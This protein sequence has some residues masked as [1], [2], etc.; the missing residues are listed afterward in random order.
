MIEEKNVTSIEK[1][2]THSYLEYAMSV[3]IGRAL[4][5]VR[6]GLKPVHRRVLFAMRQ[7]RNDWNKPYKKSA[8]VVGDVIGKY[9]PH[10]D[11]A[12]YDTIVRMAQNFSLRYTLIDGQGNFGS[13][14]GD[15]PAAMRYT[16]IR[17]RK[18]AHLMLSDIEK[19][20]VDWIPNYDET[21]EEP[22]VFPTKFPALLV[23]GSS[24]I[25]VGMTTNIPPHNLGE[26]CDG[27]IALL[28]NPAMDILDLM[29]YIPGPDFP[30]SG[31]IHGKKGIYDAYTTGR[32][33][34]TIRAKMEVELNN[35]T[36][37]ETIVVTELPYQ[38]NKARLVEKID[39][40]MREKV[41]EG[42]AYVRDESD[43]DGMRIAIGLKKDQ[44]AD[45]VINQLYKHTYMQSS[46]GIIFLAVINKRPQ[47][48]N[49]KQILEQFINHRKDVIRKRTIFDLKKAEERAHILEGLKKA[50]EHLDAVVSLIRGSRSPEDAKFRLMRFDPDNLNS[51]NSSENFDG[52]DYPFAFSEFQAQ[53]ILEM[54]LQRLTGLE[55][56]K[57]EEEYLALLKDINWFKE[58]LSSDEVVKGII[59]DEISEMRSE[60]TDPRRTEIVEHSGDID[61]EDLIAQEDMVVT[62]SRTGYIKR[63]PVTLYEIQRRGGKGKTAMGT[64][65]DD[66]VEHLFV[67]STHHTF[68]F[69]TNF[70]KVYQKKVYDIPMAGRTSLGKA[71]VNLLNFD[72]GEKLATVLT[73]PQFEDGKYVIMATKQGLVKKTDLMS[74][75]RPRSEGLIGIKLV[76]GDELISARITDGTMDIFLGSKGGKVIRFSEEE[77]RS[78]GRGSMGVIGMRIK[79]SDQVVGME[80]LSHGQTLLTVTE[81]GYGK[82]TKIEEYNSQAR[83]GQGVFSIKT[84]QRNGMMVSLLLVEESDELML[85]T[86]KGKLIRIHVGGISTIS[87]ATQGVR[88]INLS[89]EEKLIAVARLPEDGTNKVQRCS[90]S[91]EDAEQDFE[92]DCIQED[93]AS[94]EHDELDEDFGDP[95]EIQDNEDQSYDDLDEEEEADETDS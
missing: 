79:E 15:S 43:R 76:E 52:L 81:N 17:M 78:V 40:L 68:L 36:Q 89:D 86:D 93:L 6:D 2:M 45:V 72:E 37:R 20:T 53:A 95:E 24:G 21:L 26:V 14:D 11:T 44:I 88:L 64:K 1:E 47:L 28:D 35:K 27:I 94:S 4:P 48:F 41:I 13:V 82:R 55:R 67:A 71:I 9:H 63:N 73:V 80:V 61:I 57:I 39:E 38:V 31:I 85:V 92:H 12:V 84:S 60:F 18:L 58:I 25:A 50:L 3:I 69:I 74:Y 90:D 7:L 49:I 16:E 75:S 23:N 32:G 8:R 5:D 30:T 42:A 10:G 22:S 62:I 83:G 70:G 29:T 65:E 19:E 51:S 59:K 56:D 77:V 34:I 91:Q 46:F 33:V 87:R 66:F 54:R